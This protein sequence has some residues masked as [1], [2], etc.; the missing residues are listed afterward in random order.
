M[1]AALALA[2]ALLGTPLSVA[3]QTV[4]ADDVKMLAALLPPG[5]D[6]GLMQPSLHDSGWCALVLESNF[7]Q[8]AW[9]HP[10]GAEGAFEMLFPAP[11]ADVDAPLRVNLDA[12]YAPETGVVDIGGLRIGLPDAAEFLITG[13]I[14]ETDFSTV[15]AL[16]RSLT[17]MPFLG[18]KVALRGDAAGIRSTLGYVI[19]VSA[20]EPPD[21]ASIEAERVVV[22]EAISHLL[23]GP[24]AGLRFDE[25][26]QEAFEAFV[27]SYGEEGG[28]LELSF[29]E[30]RALPLNIVFRYLVF[31]E[32][33]QAGALDHVVK[34]VAFSLRWHPE[35]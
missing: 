17:Y 31:A 12:R 23:T 29:P 22:R 18:G 11:F 20:A 5:E 13:R 14:E 33:P 3:A 24:I 34:G 19:G 16:R 27:R 4:C 7:P 8:V 21:P 25:G 2:C 9:R 10:P 30:G 6:L 28:A 32:V 35:K 26:S 15:E 1:R